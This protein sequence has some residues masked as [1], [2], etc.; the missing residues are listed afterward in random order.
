MRLFEAALIAVPLWLGSLWLH[1]FRRCWGC[2]GTGRNVGSTGRRWGDHK[3]CGGTGK[4]LRIGARM[5]RRAGRRKD[6]R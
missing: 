4:R 1:P 2:R 3:R 5:V 6:E